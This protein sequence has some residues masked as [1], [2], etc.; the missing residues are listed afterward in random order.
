MFA[1]IARRDPHAGLSST[2]ILNRLQAGFSEELPS[3]ATSFEVDLYSKN[4]Q[5]NLAMRDSSTALADKL[6]REL[7]VVVRHQ[8]MQPPPR[9]SGEASK[10][11]YAH[12]DTLER[13]SAAAATS[14]PRATR[15]VPAVR[16]LPAP[17]C[18]R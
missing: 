15:Q 9:S 7:A 11:L 17:S 4:T 8:G 2:D 6:G 10:A 13:P 3:N 16:R 12:L 1:L 14:R 5:V 18:L